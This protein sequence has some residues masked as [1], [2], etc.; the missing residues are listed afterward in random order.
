MTRASPITARMVLNHTTGF[1]NWRP[2]DGALQV[3]HEPGT[4]HTYSGEG[5]QFLQNVIEHLTG[6]GYEPFMHRTL[7]DPLSARRWRCDGFCCVVD[8]GRR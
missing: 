2:K 1:P 4:T 3:M 5:L 7:L 6:E 8:S